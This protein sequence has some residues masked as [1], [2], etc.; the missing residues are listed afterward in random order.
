[1]LDILFINPTDLPG[2]RYEVNGTLILGTKL[3]QAGFD[4]QVLRFGQIEEYNRDYGAFIENAVGRILELDPQCAS[5]YT[6][7]TDYHI[8]LHIAREVKS[9]NRRIKIVFGGPQSSATAADA[10]EAIDYIDYICTGEGEDTVVPF[11]RAILNGQRPDDVPGVYYRAE[12]K[13]VVTAGQQ[14][15]C[16]LNTLP[17]WDEGLYSVSD[18]EDRSSKNYYMPIDAGRGCPYNCTFCC[19]SHFWRRTYRLKSPERIIQDIRYYKEKFG[20][21]SFWFSHDAFTINKKLVSEVCRRIVGEKLDIRWKC[22][23]RVDCITPELVQEMKNAGLTEI[24][25]GVETGSKRMQKLT[26]KNLDLD[27]LKDTI[28]YLLDSKL[29]VGLFFMYGFPEE[30][31]EDLND[32]L[33]LMFDLTDMGVQHMNAAYCRFNPATAITQEN[34][35]QLVFDPS[36][37]VLFRKTF[38]YK[39]QE[40]FIQEHKALFP[41]YFHLHTKVRDEYQYVILLY[42]LYQQYPLTARLARR[43]YKGDY[44]KMYADFY[45]KN[46]SCFQ[47]DADH[48]VE[49]LMADMLSFWRNMLQD[50]AESFVPQLLGLMEYED[51]LRLLKI[52]GEDRIVDKV[53]DFNFLEYKLKAPIESYTPG[54][55]RLVLEMKDGQITQ[56]MLGLL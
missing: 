45:E 16:D 20:I 5:F 36:V 25:L 6:L 27:K 38:G 35:D 50:R 42:Y 22:S 13:T 39:E 1:M 51:D 44:L 49:L 43:L 19:T 32:T 46:L 52:S 9:R 11:F 10:M 53:Y 14:P 7:W 17:Y 3:R 34:F 15:L 55:T 30:T 26:N 29:T 4:V 41:C 37:K 12:G 8:M 31:E 48:A 23:A 24:E 54:R 40:Q 28:K 21:N 2:V 18:D 56:R 33:K 47:G